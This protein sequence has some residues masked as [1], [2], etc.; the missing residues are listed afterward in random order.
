[1]PRRPGSLEV[2]LRPRFRSGSPPFA[3]K[4]GVSSEAVVVPDTRMREVAAPTDLDRGQVRVWRPERYFWRT[5][6]RMPTIWQVEKTRLC[7][8][9]ERWPDCAERPARQS[10][11]TS[12]CGTCTCKS[13]QRM[14]ERLKS[15]E[16]ASP[17]TMEHSWPRQ[18]TLQDGGPRHARRGRWGRYLGFCLTGASLALGTFDAM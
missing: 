6:G 15:W 8:Q 10:P 14:S 4:S 3:H 9:R 7:P 5:P 2:A 13:Q 16:L 18:M 1:M 12:N 11:A 17:P